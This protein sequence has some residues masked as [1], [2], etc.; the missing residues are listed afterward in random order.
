[1]NLNYDNLKSFFERIKTLSFWQRVFYWSALKALSYEAYEEFKNISDNISDLNKQVTDRDS[2]IGVH[3]KDLQILTARVSDMVSA[4]QKLENRITNLEAD[5]KKVS[6]EKAEM[7]NK[8]TRFEQT[9]QSRRRGA[10][11]TTTRGCNGT[12]DFAGVCGAG[13][14]VCLQP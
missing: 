13:W 3:E 4:N 6:S 14:H 12:D 11:G 2:R 5:L 9:E 10:A 7:A 1:M 8:I